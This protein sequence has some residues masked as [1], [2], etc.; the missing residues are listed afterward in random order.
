MST[1]AASKLL[2]YQRE[3]PRPCTSPIGRQ[4]LPGF[5]MMNSANC[6]KGLSNLFPK[7][8]LASTCRLPCVPANLRFW[9]TARSPETLYTTTPAQLLTSDSA[10]VN[11]SLRRRA[12]LFGFRLLDQTTGEVLMLFRRRRHRAG[13]ERKIQ[14][15]V[16][17]ALSPLKEDL[18][19][20]QCCTQ[21][22]RH[23]G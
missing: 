5:S 3:T 10:P 17:W 9:F 7:L 23:H 6:L 21:Y 22:Y 12:R 2:E 8:R 16:S 11:K 14:S 1:R 4:V 18:D 19:A 15:K 20:T 13:P